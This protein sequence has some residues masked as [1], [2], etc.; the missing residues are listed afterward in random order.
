MPGFL[1]IAPNVQ[2]DEVLSSVGDDPAFIFH[3]AYAL[4]RSDKIVDALTVLESSRGELDE[5]MQH[6]HGQLLYRIGRYRE[7]SAVYATLLEALVADGADDQDIDDV[8]INYAA[9]AVA[10]GTPRDVLENAQFVK[11]VEAIQKGKAVAVGFAFELLY[12]IACALA[13]GGKTMLAMKTLQAAYTTGAEEKSA[14]GLDAM[15]IASDLAVI[16]AQAAYLLQLGHFDE[17]ASSIYSSILSSHPSD[18]TVNIGIAT[19]TAQLHTGGHSLI[20]SYKR[21]R[22]L[23]SSSADLAKL[24]KRQVAALHYSHAATCYLLRKFDEAKLAIVNVRTTV[25][26]TDANNV[27]AQRMT[28]DVDTLELAVRVAS[29]SPT[30][31]SSANAMQEGLSELIAKH[32]T[33][34]ASGRLSGVSAAVAMRTQLLVQDSKFTEAAAFLSSQLKRFGGRIHP[35]AAASIA[36]LHLLAGSSDVALTVLSDAAA[37]WLAEPRTTAAAEAGVSIM[38][39]RAAIFISRF[40][41]D[42]AAA[43]FESI[44][45]LPGVPNE[46]KGAALSCL[47]MMKTQQAASLESGETRDSALSSAD[48]TLREATALAIG[49]GGRK[50]SFADISKFSED[51]TNSLE[52]AATEPSTGRKSASVPSSGGATAPITTSVGGALPS[53]AAP[54][55]QEASLAAKAAAKAAQKKKKLAVKR[56]RRREAYLGKLR[57]RG[58]IDI[59]GIPNPKPDPERWLPKRMRT[60]GTKSRRRMLNK[61]SFNVSSGAAQG[62]RPAKRSLASWMPKLRSKTIR[63]RLQLH[64]HRRL[65]LLRHL[66]SERERAGNRHTLQVIAA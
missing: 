6:L 10:A 35:A 32:D 62:L 8:R 50:P 54:T 5:G 49:V 18:Q 41:F 11:I 63:E 15:K 13:D 2:F 24:P 1:S 46:L 20:E 29:S 44:S 42:S 53:A 65:Q 12:N 61:A 43:E 36:Q 9:A 4:Y 58:D 48:M 34:E 21:I 16:R 33:D 19:N 25:A 64:L 30:S 66:A 39:L 52:W 60:Y 3:R 45:K 55:A 22:T 31:S 26:A 27:H 17:A 59:P 14:D 40:Q 56:S 23:A 28:C 47:A 51:A 38:H 37:A 7:S 57:A